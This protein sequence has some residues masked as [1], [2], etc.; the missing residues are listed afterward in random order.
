MRVTPPRFSPFPDTP[1]GRFLQRLGHYANPVLL[2]AVAATVPLGF[3][4]NAPA[5]IAGGLCTATVLAA[6]VL[7]F[8]HD[9]GL[10]ERCIAAMPLNAPDRVRQ[11]RTRAMLRIRHTPRRIGLVVLAVIL[12]ASFIPLHGWHAGADGAF[13]SLIV[14][15]FWASLY[16]HRKVEPW[17]PWCHP[18]DDG[19]SEA[20]EPDG[21]PANRLPAPASD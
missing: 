13:S 6:I 12:V 14:V 18:R 17:C 10:C 5:R 9:A 21:P 4:D 20:W 19:G 2:L 16:V 1:R 8:R 15:V 11:S 7:D 3:F